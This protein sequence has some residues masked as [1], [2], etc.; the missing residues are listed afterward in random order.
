MKKLAKQLLRPLLRPLVSKVRVLADA[1]DV[2]PESLLT[3]HDTVYPWLNWVLDTSVRQSRGALRPNYT[4]ALLHAAHLAKSLGMR[5]IS[6]AEFGVAGGNGLLAL[7]GAAAL[8]EEKIGIGVDVYGFD[9]GKGLP[10]PQDH[11]DLPNLYTESAY[12]M[13]VDALQK[14]LQRS[15]L[16][17]GL[18]EDT[19]PKFL[20]SNP[21][22]IGFMSIDVDYYSSTLDVFKILEHASE[23]VMPRVHC[24][25]DDTMGF[26]FSEYTG[27]RLAIAEFNEAHDMRKISPIFGLKY[28]L[29]E[30]YSNQTW[31]DQ[32]YIAHIFDHELYGRADGLNVRVNNGHTELTRAVLPLAAWLCHLTD[33]FPFELVTG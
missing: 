7:E 9:T 31:C 33:S 13:D 14:R 29:Q 27:E 4:W 18:I 5:R 24:Y 3:K 19:V 25:F 15:K 26:T 28:F 21:A 23:V 22:P 8:V 12:R 20:A 6:A 30:P 32:M 17:L 10:P 1:D 16:I 2:D 11:R